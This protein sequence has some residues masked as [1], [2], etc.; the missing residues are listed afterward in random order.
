MTAGHG[1]H[2][3]AIR[4][5]TLALVHVMPVGPSLG[6][7]IELLRHGAE[8]RGVEEIVDDHM[9]IWARRGEGVALAL[10]QT[11][12]GPQI[13]DAHDTGGDP[14]SGNNAERTRFHRAR[15]YVIAVRMH[16]TP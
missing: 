13:D 8:G 4:G 2:P 12:E 1:T 10:D 14:G 3:R 5:P 16:P 7:G 15:R 11:R 6:R 9:R